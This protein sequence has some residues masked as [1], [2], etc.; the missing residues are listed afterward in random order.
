M[1]K[2]PNVDIEIIQMPSLYEESPQEQ[3]NKLIQ[4]IESERPDLVFLYDH[5]FKEVSSENMLMDLD[6]LLNQDKDNGILSG[7]VPVIT[8]YLRSIGS[9]KLYGLANGFYSR[10]LYYNKD[11]FDRA[12]V[13]YPRDGMSWEEVLQLAQLFN[14][15]ET[16][17]SGLRLFTASTP[18]Q[19]AIEVGLSKNLRYVD[20]KGEQVTISGEQWRHVFEMVMQSFQSKSIYESSDDHLPQPGM[21]YKDVLSLNPFISGKTAMAISGND[22][23]DTI[24]Q[25]QLLDSEHH[26]NWDMVTI[27]SDRQTINISSYIWL[28]HVVAINA[29]ATN[30]NAAWQFMKY[31]NSDEYAKIFTTAQLESNLT[32]RMEYLK[33]AEGHNFAA[34]YDL[35]IDPTDSSWMESL[36]QA[37]HSAFNEA[38]EKE[39]TKVYEGQ[40]SIDQALQNLEAIGTQLLIQ[41]KD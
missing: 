9:G 7:M 37:F 29:K 25:L 1:S 6:T 33:D 24:K 21:S 31:M 32:S 28:Q 18:F 41:T 27:P 38:G 12:N 34:F 16:G 23:A 17:S 36:P 8:D 11:L 35:T 20:N 14:Q 22:L 39:L 3:K 26:L 2:Y 30:L 10:A 13:P 4:F 19:L 40:A 15:E 5:Q